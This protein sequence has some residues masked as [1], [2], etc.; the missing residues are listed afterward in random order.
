M[1]ILFQSRKVSKLAF[2]LVDRGFDTCSG[3]SSNIKTYGNSKITVKIDFL[4]VRFMH[5]ATCL[6]V[7][8]E[9]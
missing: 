8:S 3:K 6:P 5:G 1:I 2:T 4:V 9:I 7:I